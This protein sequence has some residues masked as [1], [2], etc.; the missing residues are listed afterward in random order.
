MVKFDEEKFESLSPSSEIGDQEFEAEDIS[1]EDLKKR[2]WKDRMHMQKLKAKKLTPELDLQA[3]EDISRRKKMVRAQDAILKYMVKI[4][5]VCNAQ[6]FVYGIV[7]DKGKTITGSSE[8]LREWWKAKVRF[9]QNGSEKRKCMFVSE[10]IE[11]HSL[12]A[13]QNFMCPQ[14][15]VASGFEDKNSRIQHEKTCAYRPNNVE[16]F[17]ANYV[18]TMDLPMYESMVITNEKLPQSDHWMDISEDSNEANI[19]EIVQEI[20]RILDIPPYD[21]LFPDQETMVSN[22]KQLQL[23]DCMDSEDTINHEANITQVL[24]EVNG[25]LENYR[26]CCG[27]AYVFRNQLRLDPTSGNRTNLNLNVSPLEEALGVG[28][29]N[30]PSAWDLA[31]FHQGD[32]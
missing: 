4:M 28:H 8:S 25:N 20:N 17:D 23:P 3:K 10:V 15:D 18:T 13:C 5:D 11:D 29:E 9:D 19:A 27:G 6:G 24:Q 32:P 16:H 31:Y 14:S 7:P 21:H 26:N 1:Y 30:A 2:M 22:G 12:F